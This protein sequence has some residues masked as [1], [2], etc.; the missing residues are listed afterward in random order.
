MKMKPIS[1]L[2]LIVCLVYVNDTN[3]CGSDYCKTDGLVCQNQ[4]GQ[5]CSSNCKPK[6]GDIG[7]CYDC[8]IASISNF[9]KIESGSCSDLET[10]SGRIIDSSKECIT[11]SS[12]TINL[13]HIN[14]VYYKKCPDYTIQISSNECKCAYKYYIDSSDI[15]HC[16]SPTENCPS[17]IYHYYDYETGKCLG[18][19]EPPKYIKIEGDQ[20]RCHSSCIGDEFYYENTDPDSVSCT[21]YCD[22]FIY[23]D[24]DNKKHCLNSC[25]D[26]QYKE[27]NNYCVPLAQCQ[28]YDEDI[29][30]CLNSCAESDNK[31]YHNFDSNKCIPNCRDVVNGYIYLKDNICYKENNCNYIKIIPD[32]DK[33]CLST[34]NVGEGFIA[35]GSKVCYTSCNDY[36]SS[37]GTNYLYY[38]HGD[39]QC[40]ESCSSDGKIY[41]KQGG[42]ECF[43][44]CKDIGDGTLIYAKKN[45]ANDD[46][47]CS[48]SIPSDCTY[49]IRTNN[50]IKKCEENCP[51]NYK[52]LKEEE[53]INSQCTEECLEECYDY[54][55]IDNSDTSPQELTKCFLE[56]D[57]CFTVYNYYNMNEK[58]CWKKL[59]SGYCIKP[60][61][62]DNGKYEVIPISDNYYYEV[63]N[64]GITT[65]YCVNS[66][67]ANSKYIDF[68]DKKKC[69]SGCSKTVGSDT[70]HFFYDPR[71]NECLE[72]CLGS[73][74]EF[75]Y[76]ADS[77]PKSCLISNDDKCY[78]ENDKLLKECNCD[79]YKAPNSKICVSSCQPNEKINSN[80]Q[81]SNGCPSASPYIDAN[82]DCKSLTDCDYINE[83]GNKCLS[84]CEIGEGFYIE[85]DIRKICYN[86][87]PVTAQYHDLNSNKC[88]SNCG[89]SAN[90]KYYI[91]GENVCYSSSCGNI[92]AGP[93]GKYLYEIT[94]GVSPSNYYSCSDIIPPTCQKYVIDN[95]IK[96]CRADCN[97]YSFIKGKECL[98]S[99]NGYKANYQATTTP[100][101]MLN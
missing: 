74:L 82:N 63:E 19:C 6:Y 44:S 35:S 22:K 23:I 49:Y 53:C 67:K 7:E 43:S 80:G 5:E 39:N 40:M 99:C 59:P 61:N 71:N 93:N 41:H 96:K 29:N 13:F 75:A 56:L 33:R 38:N 84:S 27:K 76:P 86:T 32:S 31:P 85:S 62:P 73:G 8:S 9:Y 83:A 101:N 45:G 34:C 65:K 47:I 48:S 15:Y 70:K 24:N 77:E 4:D 46:Y 97:G 16:L 50:G 66:C 14:K 100:P 10:C 28:F 18:S 89:E 91:N 26:S 69:I 12:I 11:E 88:I 51:G 21:D 58:K 64:A 55:A 1:F 52:Y 54:K 90:N 92:P 60:N 25:P 20:K 98:N 78:F 57:S 79:L 3:I 68:N 17:S 95:D 37:V 30:H 42:Y 81:C 36:S 72:T 94:L 2:I 87:C